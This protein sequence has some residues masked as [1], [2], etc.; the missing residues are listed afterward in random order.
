MKN[1]VFVGFI[2]LLLLVVLSCE[3]FMNNGS[4]LK[5]QISEKISYTNAVDIQV[6]VYVDAEYGTIKQ[7]VDSCKK[8]YP[9]VVEFSPNKSS[10]FIGWTAYDKNEN[11]ITDS[12]IVEFQSQDSLLT[13][14]TVK[15]DITSVMIV[16]NCGERIAVNS[17]EPGIYEKDVM[18]TTPIK[19]RFSKPLD[20]NQ[21]RD[22]NYKNLISITRADNTDSLEAETDALEKY[23]GEPVLK[24]DNYQLWIP[25]IDKLSES[26]WM[27]AGSYVVVKVSGDIIDNTGVPLNEDYVFNFTLGTNGDVEGPIINNVVLS[28]NTSSSTSR[29]IY[30]TVFGDWEPAFNPDIT[31]HYADR[32]CHIG[33]KTDFEQF[34]LSIAADDVSTGDTGV[35]AISVIQR[36]V[37]VPKGG[38]L[39]D[40][41][42]DVAQSD[43][44]LFEAG[45]NKWNYLSGTL[46]T[47]FEKEHLFNDVSVLSDEKFDFESFT[48]KTGKTV[49]GIYMF[50]ITAIDGLGNYSSNPKYYYIVRDTTTP[51]V[52]VNAA[53][54]KFSDG[55]GVTVNGQKYFGKKYSTIQ[56]EIEN[57]ALVDVGTGQG[58]P[59]CSSKTSEMK[60]KIGITNNSPWNYNRITYWNENWIQSEEKCVIEIPEALLETSGRYYLL[61][62]VQDESANETEVKVL[63]DNSF[64]I[65]VSLPGVDIDEEKSE[66]LCDSQDTGLV[67]Y[68]IGTDKTNANL[69][70]FNNKLD[71]YFSGIKEVYFGEDAE[72]LEKYTFETASTTGLPVENNGNYI[73]KVISNVDEVTEIAFTVAD[74]LSTVGSTLVIN[75]INA[76]TT[77][78]NLAYPY[79]C[80]YYSKDGVMIEKKYECLV[81]NNSYREY[82]S[83]MTNGG[84]RISFKITENAIG[85]KKGGIYFDD[86]FITSYTVNQ[87]GNYYSQA[88]DLDSQVKNIPLTRDMT[89]GDIEV[90]VTGCI[91]HTKFTDGWNKSL[92]FYVDNGI[93]CISGSVTFHLDREPPHLNIL[94]GK[95][96]LDQKQKYTDSYYVDSDGNY[97][98]DFYVSKNTKPYFE[99]WDEEE[100][101]AFVQWEGSSIPMSGRYLINRAYDERG[102]YSGYIY[103]D[104]GQQ[105]SFTEGT[106]KFRVYDFVGNSK[107]VYVN[108]KQYNDNIKIISDAA[109]SDETE[110]NTKCYYLK[111]TKEGVTFVAD[112]LIPISSVIVI[113][114]TDNKTTIIDGKSV[115]LKDTQ[116][117]L[118]EGTTYEII[119][120]NL[121]GESVTKNVTVYE[122]ADDMTCVIS[123]AELKSESSTSYAQIYPLRNGVANEYLPT[124]NIKFY[125]TA[126]KSLTGFAKNGIE[127]IYTIKNGNTYL[128]KTCVF[129]ITPGRTSISN[130][131]SCYA[132]VDNTLIDPIAPMIIKCTD[133]Y[134]N[135]KYIENTIPFDRNPPVLTNVATNNN[136]YSYDEYVKDG[137]NFICN[138]LKFDT[139]RYRMYASDK[140]TFLSKIWLDSTSTNALLDDNFAGQFV[141]TVT[142]TPSKKEITKKV[143]MLDTSGNQTGDNGSHIPT[144]TF[145]KVPIFKVYSDPSYTNPPGKSCEINEW[146]TDS[147]VAYDS[148]YSLKSS[149]HSNSTTCTLRIKTAVRNKISFKY[150]VSSEANFDYFIFKVDG[151]EKVKKSGDVD[152][153]EFTET[154]TSGVE[155]VYEF[156]Y[157]KDDSQSDGDD[158][159]WLDDIVL[160]QS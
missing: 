13:T 92:K 3:N 110:T 93:R 103:N 1:G 95:G 48:T 65:D 88:L 56:V 136:N 29:Q 63:E 76:I 28:C 64:I 155:H 45:K 24:N 109:L 90:T 130:D 55:Y 129:N 67:L 19:I 120:S 72:T 125:V 140:E 151:T 128:K 73:L 145:R 111:G 5:N 153:N 61:F 43:L 27:N 119:A 131:L 139:I 34:S 94:Y 22:G 106:Q 112:D 58:R 16:P 114:I 132:F 62:K 77:V 70:F 98:M 78:Y 49:D 74:D 157:K 81:G 122:D 83:L 89:K 123:R 121:L 156:I 60:Y 126:N 47:A 91:D 97:Y 144:I 105:Q 59:W 135:V 10:T 149:N 79:D 80:P 143:I 134:G 44:L 108:F 2:T 141:S 159:V 99:V 127:L 42:D 57:G 148:V 87:N 115:L 138:T 53:K 133:R 23:F 21:F 82:S 66:V 31:K 137:D 7:K 147:Q 117:E 96:Q 152:W 6:N 104:E 54:V 124:K 146:I 71:E 101:H 25:C 118:L 32:E 20:E 26:E 116:T 102:D 14:V 4:E 107:T 50:E 84:L 158:C 75:K 18:R 69:K 35:S 38:Y 113:N 51:D 100:S 160:L 85:L 8:G 11:P 154:F 9:F 17:T 46:K 150:K 68:L 41:N 142:L 33:K 86:F 12:S 52:E 37:Y 15:A 39:P 30:E 40:T 36:L